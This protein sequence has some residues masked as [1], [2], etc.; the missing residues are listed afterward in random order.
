M[1][2]D[3]R[4]VL[5]PVAA[6]RLHSLPPLNSSLGPRTSV[7]RHTSWRS[8]SQNQMNHKLTSDIRFERYALHTL[9]CQGIQEYRESALAYPGARGHSRMA[10][11]HRSWAAPSAIV[12]FRRWWK[13][14]AAPGTYFFDRPNANHFLSQLDFCQIRMDRLE[15]QLNEADVSLKK[16]TEDQKLPERTTLAFENLTQQWCSPLLRVTDFAD[17]LDACI[18]VVC[19]ISS[20]SLLG[21]REQRWTERRLERFARILHSP[22][23]QWAYWSRHILCWLS[24]KYL[25]TVSSVTSLSVIIWLCLLTR[26]D[27]PLSSH[28]FPTTRFYRLVSL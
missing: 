26:Y 19:D 22:S 8:I 10:I 2:E 20:G 24:R 21:L 9:R 5:C 25:K 3:R 13:C 7:L 15:Q 1:L 11:A 14:L 12:K 18:Q 6:P 23:L 27:T 4:K 16:S 28:K 17:M